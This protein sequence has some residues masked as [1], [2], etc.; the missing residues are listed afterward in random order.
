MKRNSVIIGGVLILFLTSLLA[1]LSVF[2]KESDCHLEHCLVPAPT[3]LGPTLN[4]TTSVR[5]DII[6]LT[7]KTTVVKVYLDGVELKNIKQI[8][9]ADYYGS[10]WAKPDFNLMPGQHFVYTIAHSEKPGL[11]DQSQESTYIYFTVKAP[12]K[13]PVAKA[14]TPEQ[15]LPAA[16]E[17]MPKVDVI[18]TEPLKP[19]VEVKEG[20]IEGGVSVEAEPTGEQEV[21]GEEKTADNSNLQPAATFSELGNALNNEFNERDLKEQQKRNR[22]LGILL[23]AAIIIISWLWI[24]ISKQSIKSQFKKKEEDVLPPPPQPPEDRKT[25][26]AKAAPL[27]PTKPEEPVEEAKEEPTYWAVPPASPYSPYPA[28][29]NPAKLDEPEK[30]QDKLI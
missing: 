23:L 19:T 5:P 6:G 13:P 26:E 14:S 21:I 25:Q 9:H 3:V 10:F 1:P 18:L 22:I 27:E 16:E 11:Y 17:A 7:W 28:P 2:A 29:N 24:V 15:N 30:T 20:K 4:Q 12:V 8:K